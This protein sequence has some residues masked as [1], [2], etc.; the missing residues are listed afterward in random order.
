VSRLR[1]V[2]FDC[3]GVLFDSR[4]ANRQYYDHLRKTFGHPPMTEDEL[5]YAHSHNA[6]L[7]TRHIFRHW[8][9]QLARAESYRASVDY[10]PFLRYMVMEEGLLEFLTDIRKDCLTAINTNRTT[11]M[12]AVLEM[13]GLDACFDLVVTA[14]DVENPKPHPEALEKILGHFGLQAGEAVYIGDSEVDREHAAAAGVRLIAFRNPRLTAD[15]HVRSF[16]EVARL[17]LFQKG[18]RGPNSRGD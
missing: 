7:S 1:L 16:R 8:P 11:T 12:P 3:D 10:S 2:V 15:Y 18:R 13:S 5:E 14:L 9:E 17:P 6:V 4:E